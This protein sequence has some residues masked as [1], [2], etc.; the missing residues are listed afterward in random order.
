MRTLAASK[1]RAR[2]GENCNAPKFCGAAANGVLLLLLAGTLL[3]SACSGNPTAAVPDPTVTLSGNWQFTMSPQVDS[4]NQVQFLGGLDGGFLLQSNGNVTGATSYAVLPPGLPYPCNSGSATITGQSTGTVN[5]ESQW[6]ITAVAGTQTFTLMGSLDVSGLTMNG[7]YSSTA[8]TAPDGSPCG[9]ATS[10]LQWSAVLVP[11][12]TGEI[13][14]SFHSTDAAVGWS[15]QDF[16]VSGSL[17]QSANTGAAT[18]TVSGTLSFIIG[19]YP[20]LSTAAVYGQIS[21]NYV[22]L[23]LVGSDG[24]VVGQ[25]GEPAGSNGAT[26]VNPVTLESSNGGYILDGVGPSYMVATA[27]CPGALTGIGSSTPPGDYGDLCLALGSAPCET[28]TLTPDPLV[29]PAQQVGTPT[30]Q[31][32][33]LANASG[34]SLSGLTLAFANVPTTA[35]NFSETDDCGANGVTSQPG[36]PFNL[37]SGASCVL[38]ITFNPECTSQC[39]SAMNATVTVTTPS[40]I[41]GDTIFTMSISGTGITGNAVS[42]S[43]RA[44]ILQD[45]NHYAEIH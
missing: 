26:G 1:N 22:T 17:V 32:I 38:T 33:T 10:G 7:T 6:T 3:L 44:D 21:G 19:D 16:L 41:D 8:G 13:Q 45:A 24:S 30:T 23:Q 27:A 18:A 9:I 35:T 14:G 37:G 42:S 2:R 43:R 11:T 36:V 25:I 29:F 5:A 28:I 20:C 4:Q 34:A 31:T 40:S 15:N 39:S 12:L